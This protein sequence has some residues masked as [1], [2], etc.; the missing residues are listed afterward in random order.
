MAVK[1]VRVPMKTVQDFKLSKGPELQN[2]LHVMKQ[3]PCG[4]QIINFSASPDVQQPAGETQRQPLGQVD[5]R[6]L[7]LTVLEEG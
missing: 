7:L 6:I 2:R 3:L 5:Q 4:D 1:L